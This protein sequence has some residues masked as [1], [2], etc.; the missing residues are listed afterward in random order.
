MILF[1]IKRVGSAR[2]DASGKRH[3]H[4]RLLLLRDEEVVEPAQKEILL[5]CGLVMI[6]H[7]KRFV[8]AHNRNGIDRREYARDEIEESEANRREAFF[9]RVKITH[10]Q[11]EMSPGSQHASAL[12]NYFFHLAIKL[13]IV[14]ADLPMHRGSFE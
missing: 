13:G 6:A 10:V 7:L 1:A 11:T 3:A 14:R 2:W 9:L 4:T 5:G 8:V 12:A